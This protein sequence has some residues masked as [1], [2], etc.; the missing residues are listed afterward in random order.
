[1]V[2]QSKLIILLAA[3]RSGTHMF[4]SIM[5]RNGVAYAPGEVANAGVAVTEDQTTNFFAFRQQFAKQV[6]GVFVPSTE[7]TEKLLDAF[8]DL[9]SAQARQK[10]KEFAICDIKYAHIV[11]F[12]GGWWDMLSPPFLFDWARRNNVQII[13]LVRRSVAETCLSNI[14]AKKTGVWRTKSSDEVQTLK[15]SVGRAELLREMNR[16]TG[17]VTAVRNWASGCSCTEIYY[18]ELLDADSQS[19]A[20]VRKLLASP[21][22]KIVSDFVK[23][24]PPYEEVLTNFEELRDLFETRIDKAPRP[25]S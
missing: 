4:R 13:H 3:E 25:N 2:E 19:W 20:D 11:N 22:D 6:G 14:Y 24:T 17:V 8:F 5:H 23:T 15:M 7:N 12:V 21:I 10:G 1:M 9:F 16:L 18:E